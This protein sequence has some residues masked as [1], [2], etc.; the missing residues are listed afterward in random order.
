MDFDALLVRF[1]GTD[2]IASLAPE[3]LLDGVEAIRLQF[4]LERDAGRR[5]ALWCLLY[6][7]GAAPDLDD[8][9]EDEADREAARDF[10]DEA[11]RMIDEED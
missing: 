7:L 2:D 4:G 6:M 3:R 8:A 9:F 1:F 11:D 5:F 10:M